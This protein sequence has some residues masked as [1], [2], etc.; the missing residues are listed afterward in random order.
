VP[1]PGVVTVS[2][3]AVADPT[4]TATASVTIRR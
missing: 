1:S 4:Q 2:A 3:T